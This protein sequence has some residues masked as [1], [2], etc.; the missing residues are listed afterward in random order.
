MQVIS[1]GKIFCLYA[2]LLVEVLG[3]FCG[4]K[5]IMGG[6]KGPNFP[7]H[8]RYQTL[9]DPTILCIEEK[10]FGQK[11]RRESFSREGRGIELIIKS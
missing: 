4:S 6:K 11:R 8:R 9:I 2:Q 7:V 5:C 10:A 1:K 3:V